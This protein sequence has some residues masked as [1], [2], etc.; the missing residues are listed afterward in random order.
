MIQPQST[1]LNIV[2]MKYI[3]KIEKN[4]NEKPPEILGN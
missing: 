1:L 2:V 4:V 3:F